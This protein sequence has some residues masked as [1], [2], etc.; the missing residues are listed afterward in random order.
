M[1]ITAVRM[2]ISLISERWSAHISF[3]S[4]KPVDYRRTYIPSCT[5]SNH[6]FEVFHNILISI[7]KKQTP[8]NVS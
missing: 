3:S 4:S 6:H 1:S 7:D 5:S 2:S 8:W